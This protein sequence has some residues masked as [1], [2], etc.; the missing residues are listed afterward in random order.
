MAQ[1]I[2]PR[3]LCFVCALLSVF[4]QA[5]NAAQPESP[6]A[7][8]NREEQGPRAWFVQTGIPRGMDNPVKVL[9]DGEI[10]MLTLSNR[11]AS[12]PLKIPKD[13]IIRLVKEIPDPTGEKEFIYQTLAKATVSGGMSKA[14]V[15]MVPRPKP[16]ADGSL[17]VTR[18]KSL[19]EFKAGEFMYMNL[20]KSKIGIEIADAKIPLESGKIRT[21]RVKGKG[22]LVSIPYRYSY[23][24]KEKDRWMPLSAS[25]A[26][27]SSKRREVFVFSHSGS[28]GAIR[29]RGITIPGDL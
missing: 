11:V 19:G 3:V 13:G 6:A 1:M 25:M 21:H 10:E 7:A 2:T 24:H 29:C 26:I 17:F 27:L 16:A 8:E 28:G 15:I 9:I 4:V 20:T 12:G 22:D 5:E 18:V 14:L 23:F